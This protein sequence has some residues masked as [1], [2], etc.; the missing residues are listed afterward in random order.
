MMSMSQ[1]IYPTLRC[2]RRLF[3]KLKINKKFAAWLFVTFN[4]HALVLIEY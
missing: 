1:K 3:A 2:S 4:L